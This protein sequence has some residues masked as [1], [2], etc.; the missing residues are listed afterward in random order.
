LRPA[1]TSASPPT[2][3]V[4]HLQTNSHTEIDNSNNHNNNNEIETKKSLASLAL[5]ASILASTVTASFSAP[6]AALADTVELSTGAVIIQ[7]NTKPGQSLLKAKVDLKDLIGSAIK[8]RKALKASV[9]R[10]TSVVQEELA[11]PAWREVAKDVLQIEGDLVPTI[12]PP[13]DFQQT[14]SDITN[15]KLN[16]IVDGEIINLSIDKSSSAAEDEL[17]IRAKGVKG[18]SMPSVNEDVTFIAR[19]RI[20]DQLDA[21]RQFWYAPLQLP[22]SIEASLPAGYEPN[23]G[24]AIVGGTVTIVG[25]AYAGSYAYYLSEQEAAA[26]Q[27]K[28]Q[29]KAAAEK[30]KQSA[31]AAAAAKKNKDN[32]QQDD[33]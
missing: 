33:E 25:G 24:D 4:L 3:Q 32:E 26:K 7:T 30:K 13:R 28:E 15:G 17:V 6:T 31:A 5:A 21:V 14:L 8:N 29:R 1:V 16:L 20:Q 19:T 23:R 11:T 10:V 9:E 27:A 22:E 18:V 2:L 12:R